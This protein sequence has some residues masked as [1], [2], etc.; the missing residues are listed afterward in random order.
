MRA[1]L[2]KEK[3]GRIR[4]AEEGI[5]DKRAPNEPTFSLAPLL[6][7]EVNR[8]NGNIFEGARGYSIIGGPEDVFPRRR[9]KGAFCS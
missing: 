3:H 2:A 5:G 6:L 1:R 8:E 7:G 9:K 4:R